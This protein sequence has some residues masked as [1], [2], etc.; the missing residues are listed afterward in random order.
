MIM[1]RRLLQKNFYINLILLS[2]IKE[3]LTEL[4]KD[5]I[6]IEQEVHHLESKKKENEKSVLELQEQLNQLEDSIAKK[7]L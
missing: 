2:K 3:Q 4:Q 6:W 5:Y 1:F 7:S